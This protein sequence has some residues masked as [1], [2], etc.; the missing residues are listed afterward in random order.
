LKPS[1]WEVQ[2]HVLVGIAEDWPLFGSHYHSKG[3]TNCVLHVGEVLD[4]LAEVYAVLKRERHIV[5]ISAQ[6]IGRYLKMAGQGV[7]KLTQKHKVLQKFS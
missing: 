2:I 3:I 7:V 5:C 6:A 1:I 4:E